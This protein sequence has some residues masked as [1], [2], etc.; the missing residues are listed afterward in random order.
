MRS[1]VKCI[2]L[3][4]PFFCWAQTNP[5]HVPP[6]PEYIRQKI[7][8]ELPRYILEYKQQA[9]PE[10]KK[11]DYRS[12]KDP[13]NHSIW[14]AQGFLLPDTL[15]SHTYQLIF[16]SI[17]TF[18]R[19]PDRTEFDNLYL[20][21][22]KGHRFT[23]FT[24]TYRHKTLEGIPAWQDTISLDLYSKY[25]PADE[26][27]MVYCDSTRLYPVSGNLFCTEFKFLRDYFSVSSPVFK[28]YYR[29][30]QYQAKGFMGEFS[31]FDVFDDG[32]DKDTITLVMKRHASSQG[33]GYVIKM[34]KKSPYHM[35]MTY[36][37]NKKETTGGDGRVYWEI[38]QNRPEGMFQGYDPIRPRIR[39]ITA[40]E[41]FEL[42]KTPKKDAVEFVMYE[43]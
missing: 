34:P 40:K 17:E 35:T 31:A 39:V 9:N 11:Q 20:V 25:Y 24:R 3:L 21:T 28:V 41:F 38:T 14:E 36:Y 37:T 32:K 22:K 8:K 1:L 30:V 42:I 12:S 26:Q 18:I 19:R 16:E 10:I 5:A 13:G 43:E 15:S 4:F 27:Y 2:L 33:H 6:V 29:T 23:N 7:Q